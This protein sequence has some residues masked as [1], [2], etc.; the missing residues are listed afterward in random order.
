MQVDVALAGAGKTYDLIE[1]AA[2]S[3]N[4]IVIFGLGANWDSHDNMVKLHWWQRMTPH[5]ACNPAARACFEKAC[6]DE[7]GHYP[8]FAV[9]DV[10]HVLV[11]ALGLPED[12]LRRITVHGELLN[13][14]PSKQNKAKTA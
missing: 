10:Q 14:V 5:E 2:L 13:R 9:D 3:P 7:T 8:V 6:K 11:G 4:R 1:W 12:S